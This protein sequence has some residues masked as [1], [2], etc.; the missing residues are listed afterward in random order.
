M[1]NVSLFILVLPQFF[2]LKRP[3][4]IDLK[5]VSADKGH[6]STLVFVE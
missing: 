4:Q 5:I 6:V 3:K 1:G 2:F